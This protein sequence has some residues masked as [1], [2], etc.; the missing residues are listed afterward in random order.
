M[1]TKKSGGSSCNG[2]ESAGR[3]LGLKAGDG[4]FVLPGTILIRQRG[5]KHKCKPRSNVDMGRD[6]TLYATCAGTVR[7]NNRFVRVDPIYD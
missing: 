1:A 5:T 2:R 3:R 7:Y 6:H 4:S